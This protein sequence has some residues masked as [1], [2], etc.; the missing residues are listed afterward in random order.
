MHFVK[1]TGQYYQKSELYLINLILYILHKK[2][3]FGKQ[4]KLKSLET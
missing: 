2:C 4:R 3:N 1:K